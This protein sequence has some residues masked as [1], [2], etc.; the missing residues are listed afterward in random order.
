MG[1]LICLDFGGSS[2][3]YGALDRSSLRTLTDKGRV[4]NSFADREEFLDAVLKI[5]AELKDRT[6]DAEGI[7]VSY[8]GELDHA[9]GVIYSPGTYLY[10]SGLRLK[11]FLEEHFGLPASVENDGN[12][13]LLAEAKFGPLKGYENAGMI[14]LG[15]GIGGAFLLD[16]RLHTGRHGFAGMLSFCANDL[17]KPQE[18]DNMAIAY[19]ASHYL[20]REYLIRTGQAA[21]EEFRGGTWE[22][23][24]KPMDGKSFFRLIE[25]GDAVA[26]EVLTD[27]AKNSARFIMSL[28]CVLELDAYAI[29]GGVS[30]QDALIAS[31][32]QEVEKVF[33]PDL[34]MLQPAI[35]RAGFGNDANLIGAGLWFE[36]L[37]AEK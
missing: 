30:E 26:Q 28:Q 1:K 35:Y 25:E 20:T 13:A 27:Y 36:T 16:G 4:P 33:A 11:E 3:K 22:L 8:C 29:G 10:N 23:E 18:L 31:I 7:A 15:T 37:Y 24:R 6:K 9:Q 21:R 17:S 32:Q 14:V 12:A 5:V 2:I 19:V 34:G